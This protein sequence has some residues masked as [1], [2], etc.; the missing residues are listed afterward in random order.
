MNRTLYAA[1]AAAA[2]AFALPAL[3]QPNPTPAA[4][5]AATA[6]SATAS[7][8]TDAQLSAFAAAST[9]IQPLTPGLATATPEARTQTTAQIRAALARH[10]IDSAT[11]NSIAQSAQTDTALAE[12]IAS[13]RSSGGAGGA[14]ASAGGSAS[15]PGASVSGSGHV[16]AGASTSGAGF[17]SGVG[18]NTG[19]AGGL[20]PPVVSPPVSAPLTH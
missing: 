9:E 4:P 20:T 17:T 15:T 13:L 5:P 18:A 1:A 3:A 19:A 2:L 6:P 10:N 8:Y 7:T 14:S 11:Y 16:G 12:R